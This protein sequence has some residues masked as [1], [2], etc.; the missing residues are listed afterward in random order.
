M[1][2]ALCTEVLAW[3]AAREGR[4]RESALLHGA[5]E[6]AGQAVGIDVR[7]YAYMT[8]EVEGVEAL[9]RDGLGADL[10]A[11]RR[12]GGQLEP[13]QVLSV[14][15]GEARQQPSAPAAGGAGPSLLTPRERQIAELVAEGLSNKEIA[16]RLVIATRTAEGHV[17]RVLVKL[18]FT[19]R[20]QIAAWV[21]QRS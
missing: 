12:E 16:S 14:G 4:L 9:L 21:A 8:A 19:S 15:A 13:A 7:T 1:G 10:D 20:T 6:H 18:G 17:E 5:A 3:V 2:R 11:L